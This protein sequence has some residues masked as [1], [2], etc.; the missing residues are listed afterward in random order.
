MASASALPPALAVTANAMGL[1]V[2][3]HYDGR[4]DI[5]AAANAVMKLLAQYHDQFHDWR[6][7]DY[8]YNAG[9]FSIRRVIRKHGMP[10]ALPTIPD[11][12]VRKVT[13]NHLTKLLGMAC[14]VRDPAR[15]HVT[16]P[17]LPDEQH[18]V[19]VDIPHSM[20]LARAADHAG[21]STDILKKMNSAFRDGRLDTDVDSYLMLPAS[22]VEQFT[23][24]TQDGGGG[25][26]ADSPAD[27]ATGDPVVQRVHTVR[28][29]E[30][31]WKIAHSY[32]VKVAELKRWNHLNKNTL[33]PGQRLRIDLGH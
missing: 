14:V 17:V 23:D 13:R 12:P 20:S 1:R 6:V 19:K 31:L 24:A 18:L 32:H 25:T 8:A 3:G 33:R 26:T 4:M 22:H 9:E 27:A 11:W 21:L 15:F 29:G 5:P 16:L 28:P 7:A 10:P 2:D 30:S